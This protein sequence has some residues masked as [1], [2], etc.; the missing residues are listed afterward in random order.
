MFPSKHVVFFSFLDD[1]RPGFDDAVSKLKVEITNTEAKCIVARDDFSNSIN[2]VGTSINQSIDNFAVT[3]MFYVDYLK[4][5]EFAID[6]ENN[7]DLL[8][9]Q[10]VDFVNDHVVLEAEGAVDML[11]ANIF[12]YNNIPHVVLEM[13]NLDVLARPGDE[14]GNDG[15]VLVKDDF[16]SR[17]QHRAGILEYE[18]CVGSIGSYVPEYWRKTTYDLR[19]VNTLEDKLR[20]V[21]NATDEFTA[22]VVTVTLD[23]VMP[24]VFDQDVDVRSDMHN[25]GKLTREFNELRKFTVST[26]ELRRPSPIVSAYR[27]TNELARFRQVGGLFNILR[28]LDHRTTLTSLFCSPELVLHLCSPKTWCIDS[29]VAR[30]MSNINQACKQNTCVNVPYNMAFARTSIYDDS[31]SYALAKRERYMW[32]NY[33]SG[34]VF[35]LPTS[36]ESK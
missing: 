8:K 26:F 11:G 13:Y 22:A 31:A 18:S 29:N 19:T 5:I 14:L 15:R 23:E 24:V 7:L 2:A 27:I 35:R 4:S 36:I 28:V 33:G 16:L 34:L 20:F 17:A 6:T 1:I 30:C 3:S 25:A 21:L 12:E 32:D 9:N 10:S